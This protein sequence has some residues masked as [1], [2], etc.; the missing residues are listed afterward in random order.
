KATRQ[1]IH[2]PKGRASLMREW[3]RL[4]GEAGADLI[5]EPSPAALPV[6]VVNTWRGR[7]LASG[8]YS[9]GG[10]PRVQILRG[11]MPREGQ[12]PGVPR[13]FP[14]A[15]LHTVRSIAARLSDW[16]PRI[17]RTVRGGDAGRAPNLQLADG[18]TPG[19][20]VPQACGGYRR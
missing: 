3:L 11:A 20:G 19:E 10:L 5:A 15:L 13:A 2:S 14:S 1:R 9:D 8:L 6:R 4:Q 18:R 16:L 12:R 17:Q 7:L